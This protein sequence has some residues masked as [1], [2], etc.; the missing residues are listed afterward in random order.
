M[1]LYSDFWS[2]NKS[3]SWPWAC[4]I[5]AC[6]SFNQPPLD[7]RLIDDLKHFWKTHYIQSR[8]IKTSNINNIFDIEIKDCWSQEA[9]ELLTIIFI[10]YVRFLRTIEHLGTI[11][12]GRKNNWSNA[13]STTFDRSR[14]HCKLVEW[15]IGR[16]RRIV[17]IVQTGRILTSAKWSKRGIR[18]IC[19]H[20]ANRSK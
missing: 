7:T 17:P 1:D 3:N 14:D 18:S 16:I 13:F 19:L 9:D 8:H 15:T 6:S 5:I 10:T 20:V 11:P 12:F 2:T 4:L